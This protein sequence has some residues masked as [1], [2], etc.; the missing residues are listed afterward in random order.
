MSFHCIFVHNCYSKRSR[1]FVIG[2]VEISSSQ[3]T[4]QNDPVT[5]GGGGVHAVATILLIFMILQITDQYLYGTLKAAA[6]GNDLIAAGN[7]K[8][9]KY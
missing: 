6:Y 5:M 1:L 4:R 3:G 2:G 9:I 8:W 7:V